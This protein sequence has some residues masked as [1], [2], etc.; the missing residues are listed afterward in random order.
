MICSIYNNLKSGFATVLGN[1]QNRLVFGIAA[2]VG[3]AAAAIFRNYRNNQ[4]IVAWQH[5]YNRNWRNTT[6]QE[7]E[8]LIQRGRALG[9]LDQRYA[10]G[11]TPGIFYPTPFEMFAKLAKGGYEQHARILIQN[12][13]ALTT[14]DHDGNTPLHWAIGN[15]NNEIANVLIESG[16]GHDYIDIVAHPDNP[17]NEGF[18]TAALH[19]AVAK[20]YRD[21]SC[22]KQPLTISNLQLVEN[23]IRKGCQVDIRDKN[24]DTP[25]HIACMRR[26][27]E[28]MAILLRGNSNRLLTNQK[29][30]GASALLHLGYKEAHHRLTKLVRAFILDKTDYEK[31]LSACQQLLDQ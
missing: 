31:N 7:F 11:V 19:L 9:C 6:P 2:L 15:A 20:G 26:D 25:F 22:D 18:G 13:A 8:S 4:R 12:D 14:R 3:A 1:D 16:Q 30:E 28:M 5:E 23:M 24:G 10:Q 17:A 29:G 21:F 27:P